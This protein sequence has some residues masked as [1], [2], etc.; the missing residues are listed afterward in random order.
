MLTAEASL[1]ALCVKLSPPSPWLA[2][3]AAS[4]LSSHPLVTKR[5]LER[6]AGIPEGGGLAFR[7]RKGRA[8]QSGIGDTGGI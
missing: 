2:L 8:V 7:L 3:S 1:P 4:I 5:Y 6:L